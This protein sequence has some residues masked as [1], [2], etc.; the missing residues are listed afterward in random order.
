MN[1]YERLL[2]EVLTTSGP[3]VTRALEV[4]GSNKPLH[5]KYGNLSSLLYEYII[6][7][8]TRHQHRAGR[9]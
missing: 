7:T 5:V 9:D 1:N 3:Y 2:E 6:E 4:H 8:E